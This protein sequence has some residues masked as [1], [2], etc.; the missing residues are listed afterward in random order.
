MLIDSNSNTGGGG[1]PVRVPGPADDSQLMVTMAHTMAMQSARQDTRQDEG[2]EAVVAIT[3]K[4]GLI[5]TQIRGYMI[6][7]QAHT[8]LLIKDVLRVPTHP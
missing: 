1:E 8:K 4:D 3:A 6:H 2:K 7:T 5:C